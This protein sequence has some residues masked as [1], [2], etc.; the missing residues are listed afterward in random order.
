[1]VIL[2]LIGAITA[3]L[4]ELVSPKGTDNITLPMIS[5]LVMF[6]VAIPMGLILI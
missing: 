4:V 6:L 5:C 3:T 1:M 2:A